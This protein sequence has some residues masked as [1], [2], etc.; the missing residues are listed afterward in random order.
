MK[1]TSIK[2]QVKRNGRFSVYVDG[3]YSFGVTE[4]QLLELGIVQNTEITPEQL[5]EYKAQTEIQ[6]AFDRTLNLLSFRPRSE[7]ELR[8]YLKRKEQSPANIEIILNKLTKLHYVDDEVFARRWVES[9][10]LLTTR[11]SLRLRSELKQKRIA[12]DV[13]NKVL[14]DGAENDKEALRTLMAKKSKRYPDRQKFT[15]YLARQGFR[16]DAINEELDSIS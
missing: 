3:Q 7:W 15:Q 2:K 16:Y 1:I 14:E 5:K 11:S 9:R 6:K 10:R 8:D 13:I 4:G 12:E